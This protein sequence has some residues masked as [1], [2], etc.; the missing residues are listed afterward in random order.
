[1]QMTVVPRLVR[2]L[3]LIINL[4]QLIDRQSLKSVLIIYQIIFY[5]K[6]SYID[7]VGFSHWNRLNFQ[8]GP[9]HNRSYCEVILFAYPSHMNIK[10]TLNHVT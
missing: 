1:M 6:F 3:I 10:N 9:A 8:V 2:Y 4:Y 5:N 7:T